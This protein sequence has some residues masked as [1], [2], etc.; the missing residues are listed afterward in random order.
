[1]SP[2]LGPDE[3][4]YYQSLIGVIR[5]MI[6]IGQID[7]NTKVSLLLSHLV[8]PRQGHLESVLHIMVYLQFRH[9]IRF[10]FDLSYPNIDCNNFW[11]CDRTDFYEGALDAI[12]PN[13]P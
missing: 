1:M 6:E 13:T 5:W 12:P 11:D 4:S 8:M 10:L 2:V 7:I 9:N 3:A